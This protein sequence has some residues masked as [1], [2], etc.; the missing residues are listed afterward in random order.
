MQ[1]TSTHGTITP[2]TIL[3]SHAAH[4]VII[5]GSSRLFSAEF[6]GFAVQKL[7]ERIGG[8]VMPMFA[9]ACA[10]NINGDPLRGGIGA[11][12][13]AG[14]V[15]ADAVMQAMK[16][17][18]PVAGGL[19]IVSKGIQLPLLPLP[20]KDACQAVLR[21][22]EDKLI[23]CCGQATYSDERLW[24][25]QDEFDITKKASTGNDVQPM[26]NQPWWVTD[27]VLCLR[28]LMNKIDQR[29]QR[30]L[31]L[32]A[33]LIRIGDAFGLLTTSHELFAEYQHWFE[34]AVPVQHKMTWAYTN[35]CESYVPSD[36]ALAG[37]DGYEASTFPSLGGASLKYHHRR[38]LAVG[39]EKKLKDELAALWKS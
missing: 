36:D 8:D 35:G 5:H 15:L 26:E 30:P 28:D 3:F 10:A 34:Q 24:D 27:N 23:Q 2:S 12:K 21:Q 1:S 33:S 20:S 19:S 6:P 22:A 9:Q 7:K 25:L 37:G 32:D 16:T 14:E 13:K 39:A 29:D 17:A 11:A 38:A 31:R 18:Q 4:P